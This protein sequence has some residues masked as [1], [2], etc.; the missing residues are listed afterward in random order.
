MVYPALIP[1]MRTSRLPVVDWTDAPADLNGLVRFA[2][3]AKSGFCTCTITFQTQSTTAALPWP[4]RWVTGFHRG[5][6]SSILGQP[7]WNLWRIKQKLANFFP[8]LQSHPH[9]Q[10]RSITCYIFSIF[11]H[12]PITNTHII[13]VTVSVMNQTNLRICVFSVFLCMRSRAM[14]LTQ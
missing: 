3:R 8:V 14:C 9:P 11:T 5:G 10:P 7:M 13:L 12:L 4:K 1:L 2:E 6:P